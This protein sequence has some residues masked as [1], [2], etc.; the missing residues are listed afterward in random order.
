MSANNTIH[1]KFW[2]VR[3]SHPVP[4]AGT[5]RY[6]GNT[7]CVEVTANGQTIILDGGTGLIGLG[8]ALAKRAAQSK[9]P[10]EAT[11]VFSHLHHDH[12]Q[13][14]PFFGPAYAPTSRL[15]IFGQG[16]F[17][18]ELEDVLATNMAPPSFPVSLRELP[19]S[20]YIRSLHDGDIILVGP[21]VGGASVFRVN[22]APTDPDLVR[23]RI[24]RSYAHPGGVL[25]YRLEWDGKSLV[26]ATDTEGY[27]GNDRRLAQFA[28][29]ADLLI[30]DAQYSEAHYRGQLPGFPATQGFGHSTAAMACGIAKEAGVKQLVLFHHDPN[31]EDELIA[32]TEAQARQVFPAVIAAY[33]GLELELGSDPAADPQ[34]G[35]PVD[36]PAG[37]PAVTVS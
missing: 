4:G 1:V 5:V 32:E 13:G 25:I 17:E 6:G 37:R 27:V 12:T 29:G 14:F 9:T 11:L 36:W 10:V 31:Y 2:G 23:L 19:S 30:H 16:N 33:E 26:Y 18:Q 34:P 8:R 20:K 3:G 21:S 28:Q 35:I 15:H 7:A 24:L 22:N